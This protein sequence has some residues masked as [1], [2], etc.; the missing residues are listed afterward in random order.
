MTTNHGAHNHVMAQDAH[1]AHESH[2]GAGHDQHAGHSVEMFRDKFWGTLL[3]SVPTIVWAPMIQ[4]WFGYEAPGGGV[5]SRWIP[6][7]F[8]TLVFVY[9]GY[10]V[11]RG[12]ITV[13][14]FVA[15]TAYQMRF[16]P[17]LQALMGMYANLATVRVS[18][19]VEGVRTSSRSGLSA[20]RSPLCVVLEPSG[21]G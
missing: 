2:E 18:L 1:R 7:I 16:L 6:A 21:R 19:R 9:G 5:A 13:G 12:D 14:T 11:I 17:P 10:R 8:G 3:L 4:H 15:F 20:R